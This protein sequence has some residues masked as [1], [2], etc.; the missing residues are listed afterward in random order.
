MERLGLQ[1]KLKPYI[2]GSMEKD[3]DGNPVMTQ[4]ERQAMLVHELLA[5]TGEKN[6][7]GIKQKARELIGAIRQWLRKHG[8]SW[9]IAPGLI[10]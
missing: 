9:R 2:K 7:K 1:D 3:K 10:A 6:S 5:F 4:E 8:S